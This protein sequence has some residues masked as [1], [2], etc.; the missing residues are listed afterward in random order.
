MDGGDEW[1][2]VK[3]VLGIVRTPFVGEI[4]EKEIN[5]SSLVAE[6]KKHFWMKEDLLE[7]SFKTVVKHSFC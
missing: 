5:W 6:K 3:G 2:D 1:M 7:T 4:N